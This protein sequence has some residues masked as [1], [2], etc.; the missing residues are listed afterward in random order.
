MIG[1]IGGYGAVG[2][3]AVRQLRHDFPGLLRIGGRDLARARAV[4]GEDLEGLGEALAVDVYDPDALARF[5]AGCRVVVHA[6][7]AS[8]QVLDRVADAAFAAGADYVDAG[9]DEP[10]YER[11]TERDLAGRRALVTAGMMPGLTGLLPRWLAG[12]SGQAGMR[13]RRLTA[14]VGV[15][16]RLTPAGA[17]DY[18]LSLAGRDG[19]SQAVWLGGRAVTRGATPLLDVPLPFFP[20]LVSAYPYLGYE[21]RRLGAQLGLDEVR[22]YSVFDG[23]N[24]MMATLSRLQ[25]AMSGH[26]DLADAACQLSAA[27]DLDLFGREPYQLMVQELLG[28]DDHACTVVV[29]SASTSVLTGTVLALATRQVLDGRVAPGA[30]FAAE[31]LVAD[32]LVAALR[33][34]GA[35]RAF[36]LFDGPMAGMA[37]VAEGV[38]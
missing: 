37:E 24:A 23:G 27:A 14:Y 35:V 31:G 13:P 8:Y 10:L 33:D 22:W 28:D 34:T 3:A 6:G 16:D 38:L 21:A 18:L 4:V 26:G 20:G 1:V 17:V 29:R 32:E 25:G 2:R 19:E 9:G 5:C 30:H 12:M 7:G 11:L 36:E 15:M